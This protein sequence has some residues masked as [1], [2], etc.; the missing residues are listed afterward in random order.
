MTRS[1]NL[2]ERLRRLIGELTELTQSDQLRWEKQVGSAHRFCRWKNNLLILGPAEAIGSDDV[3]RYLFITPF[4]SPNCVEI[5]SNDP[6]LG[7][8]VLHLVNLV[9]EKS[10]HDVPTDPFAITDHLLGL[11]GS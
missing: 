3:P 9:E 1:A 2:T 8:M 6:E 10:Q 4:D 7:D 11:L 5:N